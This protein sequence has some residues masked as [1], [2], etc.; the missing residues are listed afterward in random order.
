MNLIERT[1]VNLVY[2]A[3]KEA[4]VVLS[5]VMTN[6]SERLRVKYGEEDEMEARGTTSSK[7][8][9]KKMSDQKYR[10]SGGGKKLFQNRTHLT[11][12]EGHSN[13]TDSGI[14][15]TVDISETALNGNLS[16]RNFRSPVSSP[17]KVKPHAE[18]ERFTT[19]KSRSRN[20]TENIPSTKFYARN[21]DINIEEASAIFSSSS[22][23]N[24]RK[25]KNIFK[26]P[27]S[28]PN[29]L[30]QANV[31]PAASEIVTSRFKQSRH[32]SGVSLQNS[33][34]VTGN[35]AEDGISPVKMYQSVPAR[36]A[37]VCEGKGKCNKPVCFICIV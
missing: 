6:L 21:N 29:R 24:S 14:N 4:R 37:S 19:A 13:L 27:S 5:P 34:Y 31:S 17:A 1:D 10:N 15:S 8:D 32:G 2:I 30:S 26:L 25:P 23:S 33:L 11:M 22:S 16:G 7:Y 12:S 9:L 36:E 20:N 28:G 18:T 3:G 35:C